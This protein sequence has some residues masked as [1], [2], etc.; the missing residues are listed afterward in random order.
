MIGLLLLVAREFLIFY[1]VR[2]YLNVIYTV[3]NLRKFENMHIK[4]VTIRKLYGW[5]QTVAL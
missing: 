4:N 2:M 1:Y 5:L 3:K